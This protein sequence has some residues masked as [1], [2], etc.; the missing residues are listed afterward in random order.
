MER[1]RMSKGLLYC[2]RK[3][4]DCMQNYIDYG[5]CSLTKCVRDD[6]DYLAK[7]AEKEQRRNE[8]LEKEQ[9]CAIEERAA[10]KNI[11]RPPDPRKKLCAEIERKKEQMETYYTKGWTKSGDKVSRELGRLQRKMEELK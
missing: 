6:P 5:N 7:E 10:G 2:T 9:T 1:G 8:L 4:V 3:G 11:R